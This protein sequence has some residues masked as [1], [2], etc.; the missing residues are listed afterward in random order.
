M[1]RAAV[2]PANHATSAPKSNVNS[3]FRQG[4][5]PRERLSLVR[6]AEAAAMWQA[7]AEFPATQLE[8]AQLA[9]AVPQEPARHQS[10]LERDSYGIAAEPIQRQGRRPLL[11]A[12]DGHGGA[13]G[14]RA[15]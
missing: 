5:R 10:P 2:G 8:H 14:D 7:R 4:P 12:M 9:L 15:A 13:C 11:A 6:E 3:W 1:R